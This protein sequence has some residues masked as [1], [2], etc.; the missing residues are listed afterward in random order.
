MRIIAIMLAAFAAF[1]VP[2][3][4]QDIAGK[5]GINGGNSVINA[6]V[7]E[8]ILSYRAWLR[9]LD[10]GAACNLQTRDLMKFI[11]E[12]ADSVTVQRMRRLRR[13]EF[14]VNLKIW[15]YFPRVFKR[16]EICPDKAV[17]KIPLRYKAPLIKTYEAHIA[18]E[19]LKTGKK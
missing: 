3:N 2:A 12:D 10:P 8:R 14:R 9:V 17:V 7:V 4:A 18:N 5:M 13:N 15:Q 19:Q 6:V 16:S 11:S 1:S